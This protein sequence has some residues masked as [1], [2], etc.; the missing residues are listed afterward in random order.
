MKNSIRTLGIMMGLGL[1][2]L[3]FIAGAWGRST[4]RECF[5]K[6]GRLFPVSGSG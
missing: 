6:V 5:S 1:L 3:G 4:A 2:G